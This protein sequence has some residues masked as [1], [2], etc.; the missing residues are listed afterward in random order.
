MK[1]WIVPGLVWLGILFIT[2][3][4]VRVAPVLGKVPDA[5]KEEL[6]T[7]PITQIM[8]Q[9]DHLPVELRVALASSFNQKELFLA[10]AGASFQE[11][12]AVVVEAGSKP[13]PAR[14]LLFAFRTGPYY[15]V[16]Y[17]SGGY[18]LA[19]S[20]LVFSAAASGHYSLLWG[21]VERDYDK[22]AR[23]PNELIER[24][25]RDKLLDNR[26]FVW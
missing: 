1:G 11:T 18:G 23:T 8:L 7:K 19:A 21:G 16:Y 22:L 12:D 17:E 24:I 3:F 14:R 9:T 26:A 5:I 4:F 25:A 20:A 2:S 10:N 6:T 15:V 13:L